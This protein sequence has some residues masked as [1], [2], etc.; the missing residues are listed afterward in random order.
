MMRK[1]TKLK[2]AAAATIAALIAMWGFAIW[3]S[4]QQ[5]HE[6]IRVEHQ[7][8]V[9]ERIHTGPRGPRGATGAR[10][11]RGLRGATGATGRRGRRGAT[12]EQGP[13]GL[14]G[15]AGK[16]GTHGRTGIRGYRGSTSCP[17]GYHFQSLNVIVP[18]H[19]IVP[20]LVCVK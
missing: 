4:W 8:K 2:L 20:I 9:I 19:V 14:R 17:G 18:P 16:H 3:A 5:H 15:I 7:I 12:G 10:G 6:I 13:R 1:A 11:P